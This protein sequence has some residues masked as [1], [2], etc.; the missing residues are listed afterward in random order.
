MGEGNK[1]LPTRSHDREEIHPRHHVY[2][3]RNRSPVLARRLGSR[4]WGDGN[5]HEGAAVLEFC[6]LA[7]A[8]GEAMDHL[9]GARDL[10]TGYAG[11]ESALPGLVR[12]AIA[13]ANITSTWPLK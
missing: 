10:R 13:G 7:A 6:N 4:Q 11:G 9:H 8:G 3:P 5:R 1:H 2:W 12:Q